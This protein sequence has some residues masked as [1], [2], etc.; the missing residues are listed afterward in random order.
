[1]EK[2]LILLQWLIQEE[3]LPKGFMEVVYDICL[4]EAAEIISKKE[5]I[6]NNWEALKQS[7]YSNYVAIKKE[8]KL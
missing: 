1:M 3:Y 4:R 7:L 6:P 5:N 8:V 2:E